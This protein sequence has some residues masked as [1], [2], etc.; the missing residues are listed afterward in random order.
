MNLVKLIE[1]IHKEHVHVQNE[2]EQIHQLNLDVTSPY[3]LASDL[4][5]K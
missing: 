5:Y 2:R 4:F 1:N 3:T